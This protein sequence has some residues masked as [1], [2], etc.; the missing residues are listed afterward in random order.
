MN[1]IISDDTAVTVAVPYESNLVLRLFFDNYICVAAVPFKTIL[2]DYLFS[3]SPPLMF[4]ASSEQT[5][6]HCLFNKLGLRSRWSTQ[7]HLNWLPLCQM[8]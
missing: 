7:N 2:N 1:P 6:L 8:G 4:G 3:D 5:N